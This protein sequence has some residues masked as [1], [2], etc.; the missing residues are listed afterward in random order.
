MDCCSAKSRSVKSSIRCPATLG[1]TV[2]LRERLAE[3]AAEL[4]KNEDRIRLLEADL[5]RRAIFIA[6]P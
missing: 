3:D 2:T 1:E 5:E 6:R 4:E